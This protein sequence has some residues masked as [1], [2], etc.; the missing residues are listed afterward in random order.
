[1]NP[2]HEALLQ[3]E[4]F[5]WSNEVEETIEPTEGKQ[6][7]NHHHHHLTQP[8]H[9]D[10][11]LRREYFDRSD[12]VEENIQQTEVQH[13]EDQQIPEHL[14]N[15]NGNDNDFHDEDTCQSDEAKH[16]DDAQSSE[17]A[18]Q[19]RHICSEDRN[20]L[21]CLDRAI[22]GEF[23]W[24]KF[25]SEREEDI[26]HYNIFGHPVYEPSG[27]SAPESLAVILSRKENSP[28]DPE[29]LLVISVLNRARAFIDPVI[30]DVSQ[31]NLHLRGSKLVQSA[32]GRARKCYSPHGT[33]Q[34]ESN[35]QDIESAPDDAASYCLPKTAI[36]AGF[37]D[38]AQ[39]REQ[40][41]WNGEYE[42]S[43]SNSDS[44]PRKLSWQPHAS[45]LRICDS[46]VSDEAHIPVPKPVR[47]PRV[48]EA[49]QTAPPR[50][51]RRPIK[52]T[53]PKPTERPEDLQL[54]FFPPLPKSDIKISRRIKEKFK[55]WARKPFKRF[56]EGSCEA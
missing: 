24:R 18:I 26:H 29:N 46:Q 54:T 27:T 52:G 45:P 31:A 55:K 50:L 32:Q 12:E 48:S 25:C 47:T 23:S 35:A 21:N 42:Q 7:P 39:I 30:V 19:D 5:D 56:W 34:L 13:S 16:V 40:K 17:V 15:G 53:P 41:E 3:R 51:S 20:C 10:T 44:Q 37:L 49:F 8:H 43:G 11:V 1:M 6:T 33:W 2:T 38:T 14:D 9:D 4:Y 28:P 36:A 22:D